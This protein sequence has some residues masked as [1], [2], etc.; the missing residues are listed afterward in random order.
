MAGGCSRGRRPRH[1]AHTGARHISRRW[2][3][4]RNRWRLLAAESRRWPTIC[5]R[6]QPPS[7]QGKSAKSSRNSN[8]GTVDFIQIARNFCA[9]FSGMESP[10]LEAA[11]LRR[12]QRVYFFEV[13]IA[14]APLRSDATDQ[15]WSRL[16]RFSLRI[17]E[18]GIAI[19]D[20]PCAEVAQR[21][22][23]RPQPCAQDRPADGRSA[24][25]LV[26]NCLWLSARVDA[27]AEND[28]IVRFELGEVALEIVGFNGAAGRHV[29]G[30]EVEN[31]PLALKAIEGDLRAVLRGKR[32]GWSSLPHRG[33][34]SSAARAMPAQPQPPERQ[35]GQEEI[36]FF[37]GNLQRLDG[38]RALDGLC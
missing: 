37:T 18:E 4:G 17:D 16:S 3:R 15:P 24:P 5:L 23:L 36:S 9:R 2:R 30:V 32:K 7:R 10:T 8:E 1:L 27:H 35:R 21:A 19:G 22:V 29:L 38:D 31:H 33:H 28:G 11:S 34:P 6:V 14:P 20:G 13:V 12:V 26:Q 25:S